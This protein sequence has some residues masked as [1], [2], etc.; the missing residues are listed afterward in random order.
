MAGRRVE[1]PTWTALT[2]ELSSGFPDGPDL[3]RITLRLLAAMLFGG[4]LGYERE[5]TGKAAGLRTHILVAMGTALFVLAPLE[6]GLPSI[7]AS[8]IVQGVAAGIG[9]IGAGAILKREVAKEIRGLTTAAGLWTTAAVG[10]AAGLGRIGL[11]ALATALA[12]VTLA[13]LSRFPTTSDSHDA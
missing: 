4:I 12:W 8:R 10:I 5:Q 6:A 1:N 13:V 7:E 3:V 9:F 11:A 2:E